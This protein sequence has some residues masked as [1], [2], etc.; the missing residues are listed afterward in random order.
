MSR[1]YRHYPDSDYLYFITSTVVEWIPLFLSHRHCDILIDAFTY[2]R[3]N[4]GLF[5]HAYV[6]M[7]NHIHAIVSSEPGSALP[8][9]MRDFKRHTSTRLRQC[10]L[11][12][13]SQFLLRTLR[14]ASSLRYRQLWQ[15]GY[16]PVAIY[17]RMF[18]RQKLNYLHN[19]PVRKGYV[20]TPQDWLYS[21]AYDYFEDRMGVMEIDRLEL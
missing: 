7:P 18:L 8:G 14:I 9:I 2:C 6:L 17:T 20:R 1:R 4:K 16:G 19:N 13:N 3:L 5:V 21:S 11:Q 10:L 12:E 15:P